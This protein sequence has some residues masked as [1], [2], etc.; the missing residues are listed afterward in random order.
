MYTQEGTWELSTKQGKER[1]GRF[2]AN[3]GYPWFLRQF[4]GRAMSRLWLQYANAEE[5]ETQVGYGHGRR[6]LCSACGKILG[7]S[8]SNIN[9]R[10]PPMMY[11]HSPS[12]AQQKY[13][14]VD[15]PP[16]NSCLSKLCYRFV[17]AHTSIVG[18]DGSFFTEMIHASPKHFFG[19]GTSIGQVFD[20]E[21]MRRW[22]AHLH[23]VDDTGLPKAMVREE[24][25]LR[26][27]KGTPVQRGGLFYLDIEFHCFE[28]D[29]QTGNW[30]K[31]IARTAAAWLWRPK[32]PGIN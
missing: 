32:A 29:H 25:D 23:D 16:G 31:L 26:W 18:D 27:I 7:Y 14:L 9:K 17:N 11:H 19:A 6:L 30:S 5:G 20:Y 21:E 22:L 24:W 2:L 28:Y 4:M 13:A 1:Y 12:Q 8:L 3:E 15:R 10:I